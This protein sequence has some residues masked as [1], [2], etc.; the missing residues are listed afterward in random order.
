[1]P[2]A[3]GDTCD[4]IAAEFGITE[5]EFLAWNPAI[6]SD[7]SSGLWV[8]EDYCVGVRSNSTTATT[9]SSSGS[10]STA[11]TATITSASAPSTSA[12]ATES[13]SSVTPPAPT[14]S[15]IPS[16]CDKYYVAQSGDDC[17]TIAAEYDITEAEFLDWNPAISSDCTSGLWVDEAYCVGVSGSSSSATATSTSASVSSSTTSVV[18]PGPT[19]SGIASNCDEY[20]IAQSGDTCAAIEAKFGITKAEFLAWNPAVSSDCTTGFWADEAYC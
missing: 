9:T 14:Q 15:G 10:I 2:C 6:S 12:S 19:Q 7:C 1:T 17:A 5:A 18:P 11:S 8:D 20:Y 16:N 3:A 4:K 13:S